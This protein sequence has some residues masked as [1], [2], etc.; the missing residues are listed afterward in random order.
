M[1][2]Q[3]ARPLARSDFEMPSVFSNPRLAHRLRARDLGTPDGLE[4]GWVH[5]AQL[6]WWRHYRH[7]KRSGRAKDRAFLRRYAT[8]L[9]AA[10]R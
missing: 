5:A 6:A 3:D 8:L 1:T 9:E 10:D 4:R 7:A 2:D